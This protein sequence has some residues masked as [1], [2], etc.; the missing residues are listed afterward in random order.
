MKSR[1]ILLPLLQ[2][3]AELYGLRR[4]SWENT[5]WKW[6]VR[7]GT[8]GIMRRGNFALRVEMIEKEML[9]SQIRFHV[10][11]KT[12]APEGVSGGPH[13][14]H[15]SE[16][17][18]T[19][20]LWCWI[21]SLQKHSLVLIFSSVGIAANLL[22]VTPRGAHVPDWPARVARGVSLCFF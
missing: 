17:W 16:L 14:L 7:K 2:R 4:V 6:K 9:K 20:H 8:H 3:V 1:F 15:L 12:C 10:G 19:H 13:T 21:P 18:K 11:R 5:C 22:C